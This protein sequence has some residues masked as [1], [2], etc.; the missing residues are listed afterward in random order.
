MTSTLRYNLILLGA[1]LGL[2]VLWQYP[3][4]LSLPPKGPHVWRQTY[5]LS[6]V[7]NYYNDNLYPFAPRLYDMEFNSNTTD[8]HV[9]EFPILHYLN[10]IIWKLVGP[11][12]VT[13]RIVTFL[14]TAVGLVYLRMSIALFLGNVASLFLTLFMFSTPIYGFYS[15]NYLM[16]PALYGL[17]HVG[18]YYL[19]RSVF[20]SEEHWG[21]VALWYSLA[22]LMKIMALYS[23]LVILLGKLIE[24]WWRREPLRFS[25]KAVFYLVT[26]ILV[27]IFWYYVLRPIYVHGET[28]NTGLF[29]EYDNL[30]YKF[31]NLFRFYLK[32]FFP[33]PFTYF[34]LF[35]SLS[36]PFMY[37]VYERL[38]VSKVAY[39]LSSTFLILAYNIA[40]FRIDHDYYYLMDYEYLILLWIFTFREA[41]N[42]LPKGFVRSYVL[43]LFSIILLSNMVSTAKT[44]GMRY[45]ISPYSKLEVLNTA[46]EVGMWWWHND[47]EFA[48]MFKPFIDLREKNIMSKIGSE[49]NDLILCMPDH[50]PCSCL[51]FLD[52]RGWSE[53]YSKLATSELIQDKIQRGA[54]YGV[55][56]NVELVDKTHPMWQFVGDTL[57]WDGRSLVFRLK[58]LQN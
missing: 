3:K 5:T 48:K 43:S 20:F 42:L 53:A 14:L 55:I 50:T 32:Q 33:M 31:A 19:L 56:G 17:S 35:I 52:R 30:I 58:S 12:E 9:V 47:E 11:N 10:A 21:K 37:L 57:Y 36:A 38:P 18:L 39:G 4:I 26:P 6:H 51:Y 49:P 25:K 22:A 7:R 8:K 23:L 27:A 2:A 34:M 41:D 15:I 54:K 29:L 13:P 28:S 46:Y 24:N 1:I 44:V 16:D 45:G 40:W